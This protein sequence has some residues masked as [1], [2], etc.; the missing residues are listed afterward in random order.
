MGVAEPLTSRFL[1]VGSGIAGLQYALL[2]AEHGS[3]RI[4]TKKESKESNTNY[5]QGGIAAVVSPLDRFALHLQDTLAAGDGLC[6]E[7]VARPMI[8]AAPRLIERLLAIGVDFSRQAE[9]PGAPLALG[10]EGGHARR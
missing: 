8:E 5:A 9:A 6:R 1:V 7:D 10:R 4:A 3:V 2:A